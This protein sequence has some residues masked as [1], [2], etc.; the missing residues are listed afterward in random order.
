[1]IGA[2]VLAAMLFT[3]VIPREERT[4]QTLAEGKARIEEVRRT[5]GDFPVPD[6]QGHLAF[7]AVPVDGFGH[8]LLYERS[9]PRLLA[10]WR[11]IS[12]GFDGKRS[13]DDL[14]IAGS[15][16]ALAIAD[17]IARMLRDL[18]ERRV[19]LNAIVALRCE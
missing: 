19:R 3:L 13:D 5:T 4:V 9:G 6:A 15:S 2:L 12:L 14:C 17:P 8:P 16:K 11:V 18:G 7:E 1:V 10:S